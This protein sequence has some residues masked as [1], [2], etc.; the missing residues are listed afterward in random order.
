MRYTKLAL[1]FL[2]TALLWNVAPAA[3]PPPGNFAN[4][5]FAMDTAFQRP[6][7]SQDQQLDLVR[8]LGFA[9]IA[10]HEQSP[11]EAR[12]VAHQCEKR[13]L[14]MFTIYCAAQV[15]A[16]GDITWSPALPKLML[17]LKGHETIIWL[18]IGGR[19]PA[20]DDQLSAQPV[21]RSSAVWPTRPPRAA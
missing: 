19:G 10:W 2:T 11:E 16:G 13:G 12:A 8:E 14:K 18:H 7:L 17:A 21:V 6:G 15:T 5:F 9:G 3:G 1:A 4:P 20:M